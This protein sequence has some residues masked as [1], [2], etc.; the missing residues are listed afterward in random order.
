MTL[1]ER[2]NAGQL[3][4]EKF[5][6]E[7]VQITEQVA[8]YETKAAELETEARKLELVSDS[9]GTT[10]ERLCKQTGITE[11]TPEILSKFVKRVNVFAP[12]RIE[13]VFNFTDPF[14]S[15]E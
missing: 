11:L 10:M 9:G 14:G 13:V 7:S 2:Y 8:A 12:D 15:A 3:S 6:A 5:Q 4:R 1:W